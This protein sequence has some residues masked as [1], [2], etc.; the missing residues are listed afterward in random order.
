MVETRTV[1]PMRP[2][3]IVHGSYHRPEHFAEFAASLRDDGYEVVVPDIGGRH[4][5][6]GIATV[7]ATVDA[8]ARPPVVV[9]HS[10]GGAAGGA[11]RGAAHLVFLSAW[12]LDEGESCTE[13][14]AR[15]G[16]AHDPGGEAFV[17][18]LRASAEEGRLE[19]DP[20]RAVDLFYNRCDAVTARRAREL[21][22]PDLAANFTATPTLASWRVTPRSYLRPTDDN[23]WPRPLLDTFAARGGDV[24]EVERADHS[25]WLSRPDVV[26]RVVREA[27]AG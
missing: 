19:I 27:A 12:V 7:Q 1:G 9:A 15:A 26:R 14:L 16:E 18:A 8:L 13:F 2:I 23:T 6:E 17:V 4:L 5:H 24:V 3:V 21:L 25:V 22:R 10:F 20:D 11:V